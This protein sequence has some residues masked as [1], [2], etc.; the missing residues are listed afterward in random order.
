MVII[1]WEDVA[2]VKN[3][4]MVEVPYAGTLLVIYK[5]SQIIIGLLV[6]DAGHP[7]IPQANP[8]NALRRVAD[9]LV[10]EPANHE[11]VLLVKLE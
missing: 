8:L 6:S 1:Q 5:C 3:P 10:T 9:Y 11:A 2:L 4:P 7:L